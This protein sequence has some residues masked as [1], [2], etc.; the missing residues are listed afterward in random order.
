MKFTI[1][2]FA[3]IIANIFLNTTLGATFTG[4][5]ASDGYASIVS[6]KPLTCED[7][8][9]LLNLDS[10]CLDHYFFDAIS[11]DIKNILLSKTGPERA[12]LLLAKLDLLQPSYGFGTNE[13]TFEVEQCKK[14][15]ELLATQQPNVLK[16]KA[17]NDL[18]NDHRTNPA[19][20]TSDQ[21]PSNV[22]KRKADTELTRSSKNQA[23]QNT[24]AYLIEKA[25]QYIAAA[26]K[27]L[28][29]GRIPMAKLHFDAA[30]AKIEELKKL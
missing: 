3:L 19:E 11:S 24:R 17:A 29:D 28:D 23:L 8:C 9:A 26:V 2:L 20:R 5:Y 25:D 7:F 16:R 15:L 13:I 27:A 4:S 1:Q 14:K 6:E 18:S 10:N 12:R 21:V 22:L 30:L